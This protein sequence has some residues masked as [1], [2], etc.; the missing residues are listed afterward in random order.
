MALINIPASAQHLRTVARVLSLPAASFSRVLQIAGVTPRPS[1]WQQFL[2][3]LFLFS[4]VALLLVGVLAFFAFNWAQLPYYAKL[5]LPQ[6]LMLACVMLVGLRGLESAGSKAA[7]LAASVFVGAALAMY[8][9]T[10][11]T[12]ADPYGLFVAWALLILPWALIGR[13]AGLWLLVMVL[14]DLSLILYWAQVLHPPRWQG[15]RSGGP[16]QWILQRLFDIGLAQWLFILNALSVLAWEALALRGPDWLQSRYLPRLLGFVA[17][18]MVMANVL[19]LLFDGH[20][21]NGARF[22]VLSPV[23][24]ISGTV[25][26]FWFYQ[27]RRRDMFMLAV[28]LFS[29]II[30]LSSLLVKTVFSSIDNL[31]WDIGGWMLVLLFIGGAIIGQIYTMSRWLRAIR[32]QWRNSDAHPNPG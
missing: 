28:I 16:L 9:Q 23:L 26:G 24:Y 27:T 6:I 31:H 2:Q 12:G 15:W 7:L 32:Q 20:G 11:Q 19:S 21:D 29:W 30:I 4:G 18:I 22:S 14:L 3:R 1:D 13:S 25:A 8:G 5:A 10:Y 17:L